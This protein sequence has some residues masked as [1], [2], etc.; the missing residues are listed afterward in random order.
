MALGVN[1][2]KANSVPF[3][4]YHIDPSEVAEAK[5]MTSA[6]LPIKTSTES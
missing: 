6:Y 3:E 2:F 1:K 4:Y 5:L